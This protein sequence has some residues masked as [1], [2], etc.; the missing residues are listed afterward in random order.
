MAWFSL[1]PRASQSLE[2]STVTVAVYPIS[3][4]FLP[5]KLPRYPL[6][7]SC[8]SGGVC[9]GLRLHGCVSAPT[10]LRQASPRVPDAFLVFMFCLL[11]FQRC[12]LGTLGTL[13]QAELFAICHGPHTAGLVPSSARPLQPAALFWAGMPCSL[14]VLQPYQEAAKWLK[15]PTFRCSSS[16]SVER[17]HLL[18]PGTHL[19]WTCCPRHERS[20]VTRFSR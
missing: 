8:L 11:G 5:N 13:G 6:H 14:T 17:G 20:G 3:C 10:K 18:Q 2:K 9:A 7:K 16:A 4:P 1:C 19:S 12:T 15:V